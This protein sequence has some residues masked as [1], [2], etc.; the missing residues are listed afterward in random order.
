MINLDNL[1]SLFVDLIKEVYLIIVNL[2]YRYHE[3]LEGANTKVKKKKLVF[4]IGFPVSNYR[5]IKRMLTEQ[6]LTCDITL[7]FQDKNIGEAERLKKQFPQL[8]IINVQK[9]KNLL[10]FGLREIASADLLVCD[11]YYPFLAGLPRKRQMKI[12]QIWHASGAIKTFG[13]GD[14]RVEKRNALARYRY[15]KVYDTFDYYFVGSD[16]MAKVFENSFKAKSE[17][18]LKLGYPRSDVLLNP[19]EMARRHDKAQEKLNMI[20]GRR[21]ILYVPTYRESTVHQDNRL[22]V[23]TLYQTLHKDYIFIYRAHPAARQNLKQQFKKMARYPD[24]FITNNSGF[25]LVDCL[26]I[27]DV[28]ISDYSSVVF[29]YMLLKGKGRLML[30]CYDFDYYESTKGV[31]AHFIEKFPSRI[32]LNSQELI[33][34]IKSEEIIDFTELNQIWNTYNDGQ[35]TSRVVDYLQTILEASDNTDAYQSSQA[36]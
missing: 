34:Q 4:V 11:N 28:L 23:E 20:N 30:Y 21:V 18:M 26:S 31:Q 36:V 32:C 9:F 13:F 22:D 33:Q 24:F 27:T 14:K 25:S 12:F 15:Q 5:V 7:L 2:T 29:D 16:G 19:S 6:R 35:A 1:K 17:Q 8:K 3:R 10:N